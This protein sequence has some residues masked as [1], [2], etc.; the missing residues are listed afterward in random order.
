MANVTNT[1]GDISPRTAAYVV[2]DL[3]TRGQPLLVLEKFLQSKPIPKNETKSIS[4]RRYES[5]PLATTPLTEGVTPDASALT[6]SDYVATLAQ[7]GGIIRITD[8]VADT[9]ED[10]IL[11]ESTAILG[12]QAAQTV[13][14]IKYGILKAGTNKFYS[15]GT[16]RVLLNTPVNNAVLKKVVRALK[17]QNAQMITTI[18]KSTPSY[19]TKSILPAYGAVCHTDLENDIRTLTGF[20]DVKDYGQIVPM[21]G[22]IGSVGSL[23]FVLSNIFTPYLAAGALIST[24]G[25]VSAGGVNDDVYP[26]LIFARN[27][28]GGVPLK[29]ANSITPTVVNPTPSASDPL[30]QRGS[31]GWKT[32]QTAI[33]L[34]DAWLGVIECTA[35]DL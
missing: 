24:D 28:A 33:I 32:Y 34:N 4:F 13:E 17:R 6:Y 29:G 35:T 10:P 14:T 16:T 5:I 27:A 19:G 7:Y 11:S 1:Y 31:V 26:I 8:V 20:I 3:L 23:R 21:E 9:H 2:K 30:G 22:E 25:Q 15:N 18:V 12:E